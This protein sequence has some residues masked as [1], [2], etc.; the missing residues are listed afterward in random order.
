MATKVGM[1]MARIG[2]HRRMERKI[3]GAKVR[4]YEMIYFGF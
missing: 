1:M 3:D 2:T 4:R